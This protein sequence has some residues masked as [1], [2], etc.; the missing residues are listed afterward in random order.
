MEKAKDLT[1]WQFFRSEANQEGLMCEM[2]YASALK[3]LEVRQGV[4]QG[5]SNVFRLYI[6]D[7]VRLE[8]LFAW[9]FLT[10]SENTDRLCI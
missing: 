8:S 6:A 5:S 4:L 9:S 2:L 10:C 1:R 7:G 3:V